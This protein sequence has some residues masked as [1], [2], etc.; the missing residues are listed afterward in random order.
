[1]QTLSLFWNQYNRNKNRTYNSLF[2][3]LSS[4]RSH[5]EC[6]RFFYRDPHINHRVGLYER[7]RQKII[8]IFKGTVLV[9]LLPLKEER[10]IKFDGRL[11]Y[12]VARACLQHN[13]FGDV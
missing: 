5:I 13:G 10:A 3:G 12:S 6:H 2:F 11:V 8:Q 7:W 1:M 9:E 4:S